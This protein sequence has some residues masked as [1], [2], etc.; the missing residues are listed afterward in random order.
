MVALEAPVSGEFRAA[1]RLLRLMPRIKKDDSSDV[2]TATEAIRGTRPRIGLREY[3]GAGWLGWWA[4]LFAASIVLYWPGL[5]EGYFSDDLL[6]FFNSPPA[7]LYDYFAVKGAAAH[8][9]R[10]LE[11]II[12]TLIQQ[13]FWFNT[14]PIHLCSLAGHAALVCAVLAAARRLALGTA[15]SL[16]ACLFVLMAQVGAPAVLGNDCMSQVASTLFGSLSALFICFAWI[17]TKDARPLGASRKWIWRSL[18][19]YTISLFFKETAL[20]FLLVAALFIALMAYEETAWTD[21]FKRAVLL[22]IPYGAATLLYWLARL[23]AGGAVSQSGSYRIQVGL[24]VVRNVA[25]FALA[26]FGPFSTVDG[27]VAIS[28]H[29]IPELALQLAG[30]A[31]VAGVIVAGAY[32]SGRRLLCIGLAVLAVAS[33]FPAYLLT[34]VSELYLYNAI[35]FLALLF[36]VSLGSLWEG[37]RLTRA[38]AVVCAGLFF[39][40]QVYSDEQKAHLMAMNGKRAG[41]I[42]AEIQKYLPAM[43]PDSQIWLVNPPDRIPEYSVFL[44]KKFDVVDIGTLRIGP[45]FGRPDVRVEVVEEARAQ[46]LARRRNRLLLGLDADGQ[47]EPYDQLKRSESRQADR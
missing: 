7:H 38:A 22:G 2:S 44:L 40:M 46:G 43:P 35:P 17:D 27:A 18:A 23:H 1:D 33:L 10:P 42:M 47:V 14:L 36:G 16:L 19:M 28:M 31:F 25:E 41:V 5:R 26:A 9:Y 37:K 21:R 29:R 24:N 6:F 11:A 45:I 32:L 30:W 15:Q 3:A 13:H 34:H 39:A 12:L 20:G 8:A 4:L